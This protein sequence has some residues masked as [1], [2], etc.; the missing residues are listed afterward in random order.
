MNTRGTETA[1]LSQIDHFNRNLRSRRNS[2]IKGTKQDGVYWLQ[3]MAMRPVWL[4]QVRRKARELGRGARSY[5]EAFKPM[6]KLDFCSETG[7]IRRL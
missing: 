1:I 7:S 6:P 4:D 2:K 5:W 3:S